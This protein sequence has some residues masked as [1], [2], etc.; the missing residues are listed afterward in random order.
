MYFKELFTIVL[1]DTLETRKLVKHKLA[2]VQEREDAL[3][4]RFAIGV[5]NTDLYNNQGKRK[6]TEATR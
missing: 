1:S 2:E 4:E 6:Y 5:I 3:D